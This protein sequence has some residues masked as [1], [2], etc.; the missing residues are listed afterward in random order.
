MRHAVPGIAPRA[1]AALQHEA[2]DMRELPPVAR[3][4][5][6]VLWAYRHHRAPAIRAGFSGS[7]AHSSAVMVGILRF[8]ARQLSLASTSKA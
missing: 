7:A 3:I 4:A 1:F 2:N 8:A 6:A 5:L